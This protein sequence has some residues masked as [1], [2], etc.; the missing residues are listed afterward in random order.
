MKYIITEQQYRFLTEDEEQKILRLPGLDYFGSWETMQKFLE[1]RGNP[2][3]SI[4]GDLDLIQSEIE[5]L[6][7]LVSVGG[8]LSL[9]ASSIKSLGKLK[10]VG[11]N[12]DLTS[13]QIKSLGNLES[14]GGG[15]GLYNTPLSETTT[16][17]EIRNQVDIRGNIYM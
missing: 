4:E 5:S 3:Y 14:V 9:V 8:E 2:L 13:T 1:K 7:N 12:L 17:E 11:G 16:K 10:S 15:L 6:G